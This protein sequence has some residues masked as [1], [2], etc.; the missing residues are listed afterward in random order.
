MT[1]RQ[2]K[3]I[4]EDF[5]L[6]LEMAGFIPEDPN[7]TEQDW[8]DQVTAFIDHL[9]PI[10]PPQPALELDVCMVGGHPHGC[11]C[12]H[13]ALPSQPETPEQPACS[14]CGRYNCYHPEP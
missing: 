3:D 2:L 1:E 7:R 12:H 9:G 10:L 8:E 6:W 11:R 4:L 13:K 14:R 5:T